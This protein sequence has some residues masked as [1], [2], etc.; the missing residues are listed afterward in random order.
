MNQKNK[1]FN[2][3]IGQRSTVIGFL[4][5]FGLIGFFG[6]IKQKRIQDDTNR[7]GNMHVDSE[8]KTIVEVSLTGEIIDPGNYR[9][10]RGRTLVELI[11]RAGGLTQRA[12]VSLIDLNYILNKDETININ[13]KMSFLQK[14]GLGKGP[15]E[16]YV[17]PPV[18]I[19]QG[20]E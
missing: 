12:D 16:T 17:D 2:I 5:L 15:E 9:I 8:K 10:E 14:L 19:E 18:E 7:S 1:Y 11:E 3:K 20:I 4:L 13:R 6:W